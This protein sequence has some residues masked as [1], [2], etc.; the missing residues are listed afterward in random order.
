MALGLRLEVLDSET[1]DVLIFSV[2]DS[3]TSEWSKAASRG[4]RLREAT[5]AMYNETPRP[6]DLCSLD[7]LVGFPRVP[8][9]ALSLSIES[10]KALPTEERVIECL[11]FV[12]GFV[13]RAAEIVGSAVG[14][15]LWTPVSGLSDTEDEL[16]LTG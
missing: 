11:I 3:L 2:C 5:G 10:A 16:K 13:G 12:G 7:F 9:S 4:P 1:S 15:V 8:R 6:D 14:I